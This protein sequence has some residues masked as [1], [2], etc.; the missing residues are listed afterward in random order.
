MTTTTPAQTSDLAVT[1]TATQADASLI[2][3]I[4]N[5]P[6][7]AKAG[8][9]I[10]L[11]FDYDTPPTYEQLT[12]DHPKGSQGYKDIGAVM[13]LNET[14]GTF[15]KQGLLDRGLVYDLLYVKGAWDR[16]K[17]IAVHDREKAGVAALWENFEALANGQG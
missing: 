1:Y 7:A 3:A 6:I 4:F 12:A 14:I 5:G 17:A 15:V 8:D 11:L 10:A 9:G 16:V 13:M 2:M